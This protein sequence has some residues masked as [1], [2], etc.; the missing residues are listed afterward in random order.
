LSNFGTEKIY[1]KF[2]SDLM[3]FA[4]LCFT[5]FF[6]IL[7]PIGVMPVF[8]TMTADL[9]SAAQTKTARKAALTSFVTWFHLPLQVSSCF[10][11]SAFRLIVF[12]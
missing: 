3:A 4:L 6:T 7:N 1:K 10:S 5:S 12:G 11:F 2:M 9:D 8:M